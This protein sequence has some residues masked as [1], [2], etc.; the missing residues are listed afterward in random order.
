VTRSLRASRTTAYA[1]HIAV[2][3]ERR[4]YVQR[5][6]PEEAFLELAFRD[7]YF[8]LR[9]AIHSPV[10]CECQ[11]FRKSRLGERFRR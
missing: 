11:P 9:C 2:A 6:L 5:N 10:A 1:E 4:K 7:W 3:K 8:D